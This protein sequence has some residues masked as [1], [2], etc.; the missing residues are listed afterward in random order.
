MSISP[1][2][3][4]VLDVVKAVNPT[5]YAVAARRL[6][7]LAQ[8]K[9]PDAT[10]F[11]TTMKTA[12]DHSAPARSQP[13]RTFHEAE[14]RVST[15]NAELLAA[16]KRAAQNE[17]SNALKKAH[18]KLEGVFLQGI[19]KSMLSGSGQKD[20]LFGDGIAGDYWKS[21][22]AEAI[23]NQISKGRGIGI[24]ESLSRQSPQQK[25]NPLTVGTQSDYKQFFHKVFLDEV[26][27]PP[28]SS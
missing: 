13:A 18:Q 23:A 10:T 26:T 2:S 5:R 6:E 12:I 8:A 3:D 20:K 17:P 9:L 4:I 16:V 25:T 22:M 24:A 15:A 19:I 11:S 1:P 28:R 21:F 27:A 14:A 7:K